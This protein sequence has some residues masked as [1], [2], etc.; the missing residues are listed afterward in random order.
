MA[1]AV[2]TIIF[3]MSTS[4]A[5]QTK[6]VTPDEQII[7]MLKCFYNSYIIESDK[8]QNGKVTDSILERY[9]T[10]KFLREMM[11]MDGN[12]FVKSQDI[13]PDWLKTLDIKK[14]RTRKQIY[15]VSF[16]SRWDNSRT[17]ITIKVIKHN[18]EYRIDSVW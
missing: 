2:G 9:C 13:D 7:K 1:I 4:K 3:L 10:K 8:Q 15:H 16:Y 18:G 12:P 14:D 17:L 5:Y 6:D 11:D